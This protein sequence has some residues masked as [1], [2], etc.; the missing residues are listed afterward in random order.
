MSY[1]SLLLPSPRSSLLPI[2]AVWEQ[3]TS[4]PG[5][6]LAFGPTPLSFPAQPF[7][8]SGTRPASIT[9][10]Q[11]STEA[12]FSLSLLSYQLTPFVTRTPVNTLEPRSPPHP[13]HSL[14]PMPAGF[15][16]APQEGGCAVARVRR[17]PAD[18]AP[19]AAERAPNGGSPEPQRGQGRELRSSSGVCFPP[20]CPTI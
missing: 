15:I 13:F 9:A 1:E 14:F 5:H 18:V 2:I 8:R 11:A 20:S 17:V 7:C 3:E 10:G 6:S 16:H 12:S 4:S 19:P